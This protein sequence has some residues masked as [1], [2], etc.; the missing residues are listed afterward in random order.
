[1]KLVEVLDKP[2]INVSSKHRLKYITNSGSSDGF[3]KK[4]FCGDS[5]IKADY[6]GYQGLAE[7]L[8]YWL[9]TYTDIPKDQY[10]KYNVCEIWE[11]GNKVGNGCVSED[12]KRGRK[13]YS[14]VKLLRQTAT[15]LSDSY[16][17][18][19]EAVMSITGIDPKDYIDLN[20]Y[21]DAITFN[22]DR[23][24]RNMSALLADDG[25]WS[26]SPIFDNGDACLSNTA[27]YPM[28]ESVESCLKR[29]YAKPFNTDFLK[30]IEFNKLITIHYDG[31]VSSLDIKSDYGKR[32]LEV[33]MIGLDR[34][35]GTV[36]TPYSA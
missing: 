16:E 29:V 27:M 18:V 24:F 11:D 14:F 12:F 25:T 31:F 7:K 5:Y 36:W 33:L 17:E 4:W 35:K 22:G 13:E 2:R 26:Y 15:P 32:A 1:M 6:C 34:T 28:N 19:R 20:L 8:V 9:L 10:V 30:Q 21:I 3:Q 23:H